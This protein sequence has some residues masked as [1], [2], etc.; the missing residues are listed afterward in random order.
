MSFRIKVPYL[1]N[2]TCHNT[3]CTRSHLLNKYSK[4]EYIRSKGNRLLNPEELTIG[5]VGCAENLQP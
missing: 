2:S 1:Q 4:W 5:E 3:L